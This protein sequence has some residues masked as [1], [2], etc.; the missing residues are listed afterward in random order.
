MAE[1]KIRLRGRDTTPQDAYDALRLTC[2]AS[3]VCRRTGTQ[4]ASRLT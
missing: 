4:M 3:A 1:R 2:P